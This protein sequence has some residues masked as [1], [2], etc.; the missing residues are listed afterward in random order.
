MLIVFAPKISNEMINQLENHIS[1]MLLSLRKV[2]P[3]KNLKPKDHFLI[4]Y[5]RV[6]RE[7]GPLIFLWC[8]RFEA[9]HL[10]FKKLAQFVQ[11]FVNIC[12]TASYHHQ[13][14]LYHTDSL[15]TES[16]TYKLYSSIEEF[17]YT[18]FNGL[19]SS[20]I[21]EDITFVK[22]VSCSNLKYTKNLFI[23]TGV[24]GNLPVFQEIIS[25]FLHDNRAFF[26][27]NRWKTVTLHVDLIAYH[28]EKI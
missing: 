18:C 19:L 27:L 1:E 22:S 24:E 28:I 4:H 2:F 8:M 6:I 23:L 15:L 5:P 12:T 25:I 7:M 20:Q 21:K 10:P 17:D 16:L 11:N 9:K 13:E 14:C 3:N 26:I